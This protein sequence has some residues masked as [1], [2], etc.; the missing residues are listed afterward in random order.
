MCTKDNQGNWDRTNLSIPPD[1]HLTD[2][3]LVHISIEIMKP[4]T[5]R[6][7][8]YS[9]FCIFRSSGRL[10]DTRRMAIMVRC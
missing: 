10:A 6:L 7:P 9:R 5:Y 8:P 2:K 3:S 4:G 1:C